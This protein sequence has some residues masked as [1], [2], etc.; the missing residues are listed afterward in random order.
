MNQ[1]WVWLKNSLLFK[2]LYRVELLFSL[3]S[4]VAGGTL[5]K[6][7][8]TVP[9]VCVQMAF[10]VPSWTGGIFFPFYFNFLL[11]LESCFCSHCSLWCFKLL[12]GV[13]LHPIPHTY[14]I[15][16]SSSYYLP[17]GGYYL[18]TDRKNTWPVLTLPG[19]LCRSWHMNALTPNPGEFPLGPLYLLVKTSK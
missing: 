19:S 3:R 11:Y 7:S 2:Q 18:I 15:I 14:C 17:I 13:G 8:L 4:S 5:N 9:L 10:W 12:S 1:S 6:V 16:S